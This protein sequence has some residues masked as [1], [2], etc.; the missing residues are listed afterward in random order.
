MRPDGIVMP[1]PALDEHLSFPERGK[2]FHIEQLV[3]QLGIEALIVPIFPCIAR[4]ALLCNAERGLP[5]SI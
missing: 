1:P 2:D 5:G 3:A 4:Q